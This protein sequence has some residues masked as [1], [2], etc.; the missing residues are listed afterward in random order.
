MASHL[1][2][3]DLPLSALFSFLFLLF[4][5]LGLDVLW[6]HQLF[7]WIGWLLYLYSGAKAYFEDEASGGEEIRRSAWWGL[8]C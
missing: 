8:A 7:G 4:S 3:V 2:S 5:F 1:S 6:P